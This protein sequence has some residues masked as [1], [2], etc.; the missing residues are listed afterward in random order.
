MRERQAQLI[1]DVSETDEYLD[2]SGGVTRSGLA[3]VLRQ[4]AVSTGEVMGVLNVEH[5]GIGGLDDD[6]RSQL[7]SLSDLVVAA[8]QSTRTKRTSAAACSRLL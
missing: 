8:I 1:A 4:D 7:I 6:H 2:V 5:T 3:V